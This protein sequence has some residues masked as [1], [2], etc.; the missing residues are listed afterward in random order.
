MELFNVSMSLRN[1][2]KY[3][4]GSRCRQE[5]QWAGRHA[6]TLFLNMPQIKT[7]ALMGSMS[8]V[9]TS[10]SLLVISHWKEPRDS[11]HSFIDEIQYAL[12]EERMSP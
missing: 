6:R 11:Q 7:Q 2:L 1:S 3:S 4:T 10:F 8:E 9:W 5:V 12:L